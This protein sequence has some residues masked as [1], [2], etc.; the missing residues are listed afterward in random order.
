[1]KLGTDKP[2]SQA[3]DQQARK[4]GNPGVGVEE[5]VSPH[6]SQKRTNADKYIFPGAPGIG[7]DKKTYHGNK[8]NTQLDHTEHGG[9]TAYHIEAA[10]P[11]KAV[12]GDAQGDHKGGHRNHKDNIPLFLY[13]QP[14]GV[15]AGHKERKKSKITGKKQDPA[16]HDQIHIG[17][18]IY[19]F[20]GHHNPNSLKGKGKNKKGKKKNFRGLGFFKKIINQYHGNKSVNG[21]TGYGYEGRIG[22]GFEKG[23]DKAAEYTGGTPDRKGVYSGIGREDNKKDNNDRDQKN[24]GYENS[25]FKKIVSYR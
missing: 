11:G 22:I 20:E 3:E 14:R 19:Y 5:D 21:G 9:I 18:F 8:G 4:R 2:G 1:V 25:C 6:K 24:G 23:E 15:H 12:D 10:I 17:Q 16:I 7:G 13:F